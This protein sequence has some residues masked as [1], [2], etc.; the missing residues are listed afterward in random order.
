MRGGGKERKERLI[1]GC[2]DTEKDGGGNAESHSFHIV[3]IVA[4]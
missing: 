1:S 4:Y 3:I 2:S